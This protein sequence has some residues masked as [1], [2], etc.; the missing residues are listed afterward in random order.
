MFV[1]KSTL[2]ESR[3]TAAREAPL[4]M[5]D[6]NVVGTIP[7]PPYEYSAHTGEYNWADFRLPSLTTTAL[8]KQPMFEEAELFHSL[9]NSLHFA[10]DFRR[11]AQ[12]SLLTDT[13]VTSPEQPQ[14]EAQQRCGTTA[15]SLGL[16]GDTAEW[17][18]R[19]TA[20]DLPLQG[21]VEETPSLVPGVGEKS[22]QN[23]S[24]PSM[25]DEVVGPAGA[26]ASCRP[27]TPGE[28][29]TSSEAYSTEEHDEWA[30][31]DVAVSAK[32]WPSASSPADAAAADSAAG[33]ESAE[34]RG[35]NSGS[36]SGVSEDAA[37]QAAQ[38]AAGV[39][40]TPASPNA[41]VQ[42]ISTASTES[43]LGT[44]T[45]ECEEDV[46]SETEEEQVL[47][48]S[49]PSQW[50][51][52]DICVWLSWLSGKFGLPALDAAKFP[53][54][55]E[56]LCALT[57]EQ[58]LERTDARSAKILNDFLALRKKDQTSYSEA[59]RKSGWSA[60]SPT[61]GGYEHQ[62]S[63]S[64][65]F[66]AQ[67]LTASSKADAQSPQRSSTPDSF[68]MFRAAS[69]RFSSQ[70]TGQIQLWQFLLELLSD[71]SNANCITWEGQNGEFKLID[72]DEV[73]RRWGE[74]KSKPNMNYD[75]LSRALR[76]YYDKNIMTK[77]HGKRYAYKF[78]FHGLTQAQQAPTPESSAAY[79]LQTELLLPHYRSNYIGAHQPAPM[80]LPPSAA[81]A[82]AA[83]RSP[84]WTPSATGA[85]NLYPNLSGHS[86]THAGHRANG[87]SH[88]YT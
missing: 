19:R 28:R 57:P 12:T 54:N 66:S 35:R 60:G 45:L 15:A 59:L 20:R 16:V 55:G 39:N 10:E 53:D 7:T 82:A 1:A 61:N 88:Y 42:N 87:L 40:G 56:A 29:R 48:P 68:Q 86:L 77:V 33:R 17:F 30:I 70:G 79:R 52:S 32:G 76:Y 36:L 67:S 81:A 75:K 65:C 25:Y 14:R 46:E 73:A 80:G 47:L 22:R 78:D 64:S 3:E 23:S 74:R 37:S 49:D 62:T 69:A 63:V 34:R 38:V 5:Q 43:L 26:T 41:V 11:T 4:T 58:F 21:L 24:S 72:P 85:C 50:N 6:A 84:Y 27:E 71:S 9:C 8:P 31:E 18:Q 83:V 44:V 2:I 13:P 51:G